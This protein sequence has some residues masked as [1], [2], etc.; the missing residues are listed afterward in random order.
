LA[1]ENGVILAGADTGIASFTGVPEFV[2]E[3]H[4]SQGLSD[5][6]K[7]LLY[8]ESEEKAYLANLFHKGYFPSAGVAF[9]AVN[10]YSKQ[11][12]GSDLGP[13]VSGV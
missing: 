5:L 8:R 7:H 3:Y 6:A 2:P 11:S 12:A 9:T 10:Q 4:L 13:D 1:K